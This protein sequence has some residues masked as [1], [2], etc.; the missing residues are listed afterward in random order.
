MR[1]L[2]AIQIKILKFC[3]LLVSALPTLWVVLDIYDNFSSN[4]AIGVVGDGF[5]LVF[6][7]YL[8]GITG[9]LLYSGS[10]ATSLT[11]FLFYPRHY[12]KAPPVITTRQQGLIAAN[13][14]QLAEKE[15]FEL[16]DK[17]PASPEIALMIADLHAGT[18]ASPETAIADVL[19]YQRYRRLRYHQLN[20]QLAMRCT[21]FYTI[22]NRHGEAVEMLEKELTIP[23]I[24]TRRERDVLRK[25]INVLSK[26]LN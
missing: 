13:K 7:L 26:Q 22:L 15:L 24:Y 3:A 14:F 6:T 18:F 23:F 16:R 4:S 1:Q 17:N 19:Y 8:F 11:D 21:D 12:L 2:S 10:M 25:R 5:L 20:L 9:S